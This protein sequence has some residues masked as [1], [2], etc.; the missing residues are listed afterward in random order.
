MKIV[1][2]KDTN[3][4]ERGRKKKKQNKLKR[5]SPKHTNTVV[6]E[7][8]V[9][10]EEKLE[11]AEVNKEV[12][13]QLVKNED[14]ATDT[15][16]ESSEIDVPDE[17]VIVDQIHPTKGLKLNKKSRNN[18]NDNESPIVDD[19]S[20]VDAPEVKTKGGTKAGQGLRSVFDV[21]E[22][23][24]VGAIFCVIGAQVGTIVLKNIITSTVGG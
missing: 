12:E 13:S 10:V 9:D 24:V 11:K 21:L 3:N 18:K 6:D 23:V 5:S 2:A 8:I 14:A 22:L 19:N 17:E 4:I 1:V 20:D 15:I 16:L 7:E